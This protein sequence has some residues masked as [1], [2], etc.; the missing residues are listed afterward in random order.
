MCGN[1]EERAW[2]EKNFSHPIPGC[3][4]FLSFYQA[5]LKS[6]RGGGVPSS[7]PARTGTNTGITTGAA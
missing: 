3:V 7:H 1:V 4:F 5:Q 6:L 2:G